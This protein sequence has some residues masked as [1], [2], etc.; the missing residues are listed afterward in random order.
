MS[1]LA[2]VNP[3]AASGKALRLWQSLEAQAQ[4]LF[5]DLEVVITQTPEELPRL[6]AKA[7]VQGVERVLSIGGDG[8]NHS[9]VNALMQTLKTQRGT[10][11]PITFGCIPAGT[12]RDWA[13]GVGL[14]MQPQQALEHLAQAKARL[15]DVGHIR[16]DE[17]E[18][19]FLNIA[20][21][22]I[23]AEVVKNVANAPVKRPW[24]FLQATLKSLLSYQPEALEL[25]CDGKLF[26]RG[27][28]YVTAVANGRYFG[29][30]MHVAP[31]A[32]VD[33]GLFEV[34]VA[35]GMGLGQVLPLL[36]KLYQGKHI[37]QARIH[38]T[39]ARD[40]RIVSQTGKVLGM[41]L[42]GEPAFGR[43]IVYRV[44]PQALALLF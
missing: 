39:Q 32:Q 2:I 5:H 40:V 8:T 6:L 41:D 7:Q 11:Q 23:S 38:H 12:G 37:D 31:M 15:V 28:I 30:G 44:L 24:T 9:V 43:E 33:D 25:Y 21:S 16:Y 19:Y 10:S 18:A 4:R 26:Y 36:G 29:Q 3:H 20:T 42:D 22:G 1:T 34:I 17:R 27:N 14:P 13:R 35:E